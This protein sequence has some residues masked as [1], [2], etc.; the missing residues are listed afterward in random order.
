[1][2]ARKKGIDAL[3]FSA[4]CAPGAS[5]KDTNM[6]TSILLTQTRELLRQ[7]PKEL[8]FKRI[9]GETGLNMSWISH[10]SV[11]D[12]DDPGVKKVET[13]WRYLTGKELQL[14]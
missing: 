1:M 12:Y 11:C 7:R 3:D 8:S 10:F 4:Q 5:F 6:P 13:L 2:E 14:G 9:A